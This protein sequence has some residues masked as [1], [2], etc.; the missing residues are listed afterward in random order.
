MWI[1]D[2]WY[3]VVRVKTDVLL[4][5]I[6]N[7]DFTKNL[8]FTEISGMKTWIPKTLIPGCNRSSIMKLGIRLASLSIDQSSMA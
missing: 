7:G 2:P 3:G 1:F 6:F 4:R 5:S 8:H